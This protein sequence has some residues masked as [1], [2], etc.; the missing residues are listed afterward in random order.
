[1]RLGKSRHTTKI[2]GGS[3]GSRESLK[4]NKTGKKNPGRWKLGP[5]SV[6]RTD[7]LYL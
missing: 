6:L 3:M 5:I 2:M 1:M 4:E 7:H